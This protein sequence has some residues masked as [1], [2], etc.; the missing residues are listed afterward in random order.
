MTGLRHGNPN[1]RKLGREPPFSASFHR[2][3]R[4]RASLNPPDHL[5]GSG[6]KKEGDAIAFLAKIGYADYRNFFLTFVY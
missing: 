1:M 4:K 6:A 3:I 2:L 5:G